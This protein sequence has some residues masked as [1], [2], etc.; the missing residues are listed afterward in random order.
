MNKRLVSN[1][2]N[3]GAF[4]GKC[5]KHYRRFCNQTTWQGWDFNYKEITT[6]MLW[7][8]TFCQ[9][10]WR[11][12]NT[13]K[14]QLCLSLHGRHL[15][16]KL[17]TCLIQNFSPLKTDSGLLNNAMIFFFFYSSKLIQWFHIQL[18]WNHP[19]ENV[20]DEF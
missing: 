9:S 18:R 2:G 4:V 14:H 11:T 8:L 15:T 13:K 7:V 3:F 20:H 1:K 17:L 12:P 6:L 10:E 5:S 16:H 19:L